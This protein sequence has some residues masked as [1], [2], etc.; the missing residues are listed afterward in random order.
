[1]NDPP[2]FLEPK[3]IQDIFTDKFYFRPFAEKWVTQS[4]VENEFTQ[5][6]LISEEKFYEQPKEPQPNRETK[7]KRKPRKKSISEFL[8]QSG[9]QWSE[10]EHDLFLK[11]YQALGN[12]WAIISKCYVKTRDSVMNFIY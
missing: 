8:T 12:Q 4:A 3:L 5:G 2:P 1:M 6:V 7:K 10:E 11:G 9:G